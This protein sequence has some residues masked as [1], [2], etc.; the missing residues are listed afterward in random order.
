MAPPDPT[1]PQVINAEL[2]AE[3]VRLLRLRGPLGELNVSDEVRLTFGLGSAGFIK[4][5]DF[6]R[7]FE[8]SSFKSEGILT[9]SPVNTLHADTGPLAVGVYDLIFTL[10]KDATSTAINWQFQWRN[11]DNT[12]NLAVLDLIGEPPSS[13]SLGFVVNIANE[14]LRVLNITIIPASVRA[15]AN[16]VIAKRPDPGFVGAL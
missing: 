11:F 10:Q 2:I 5:L 15:I 4:S 3:V 9:A 8:P 14:R 6:G 13:V 12:V 7:S 16:F 1:R